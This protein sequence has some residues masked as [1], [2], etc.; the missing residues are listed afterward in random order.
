MKAQ[1][2]IKRLRKRKY[3]VVNE[4]DKYESDKESNSYA[5]TDDNDFENEHDS[6]H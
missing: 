4:H 6:D 2:Q 5:S 1:K 3:Y